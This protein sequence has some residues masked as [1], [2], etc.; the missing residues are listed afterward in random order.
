MTEEGKIYDY[1]ND[2]Q[3]CNN[4]NNDKVYVSV[5]RN[6][7]SLFRIINFSDESYSF[8]D[9]ERVKRI[10]DINKVLTKEDN[11]E[12]NKKN[13]LSIVNSVLDNVYPITIPYKPQTI[14]AFIEVFPG[15]TSEV[16]TLGILYF[17]DETLG[18][19][20]AEMIE[21]KTYFRIHPKVNINHVYEELDQDTYNAVKEKWIKK[22]E[23][24]LKDE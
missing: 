23:E 22:E 17:R 6:Y 19:E 1:E 9:I 8:S 10:R 2:W 4:G 20:D 11:E 24:K 3:P 12:E 15:F 21:A 18:L 13:Y 14:T 16:D 5:N 7:S